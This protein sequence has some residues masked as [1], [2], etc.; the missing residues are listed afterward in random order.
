MRLLADLRAKRR[1]RAAFWS[2]I[3][4]DWAIY[5]VLWRVLDRVRAWS[6][7]TEPGPA[8]QIEGHGGEQNLSRGLGQADIA[9]AGE[10]HSVLEGGEGRFHR[11]APPGDQSVVAGQP[12]RK[13]GM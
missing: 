13:F 6:G 8:A 5:P 3:W 11:R 2:P 12:G 9:D 4:A 10:A 7:R 1:V